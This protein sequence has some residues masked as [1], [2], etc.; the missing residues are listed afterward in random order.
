MT[1]VAVFSCGS[2][3]SNENDKVCT[4]LVNVLEETFSDEFFKEYSEAEMLTVITNSQIIYREISSCNSQLSFELDT[5]LGKQTKY[6]SVDDY[7]HV[8]NTFRIQI[9]CYNL[10]ESPYNVLYSTS[11][12]V[13][14]NGEITL[15]KENSPYIDTVQVNK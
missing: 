7:F 15:M 10:N 13:G 14:A 6:L 5:L 2:S 8:G 1:V 11:Y 3:S 12:K 4:T 9:G